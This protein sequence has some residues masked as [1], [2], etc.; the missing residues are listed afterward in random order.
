VN[1]QE[2]ALES[3]TKTGRIFVLDALRGLAAFT[4]IWHHFHFAFA[5]AQS[6]R[7]YLRPF[8]AG[9]EAVMLFFVLSGYV[10]S[11]AVWHGK[12]LPYPRYLIR[13]LTRIYLPYVA[14][15]L[16]SVVVGKHFLFSRLPLHP[17]FYQTWQ[18]PI[19]WRVIAG[20]FMVEPYPKLNTSFWSLQYE[21]QMSL[22]FPLLCRIIAKFRTLGTA[23][24]I[25]GLYWASVCVTRYTSD[26]YFISESLEYCTF[27]LMGALIAKSQTIITAKWNQAGITLKVLITAT[28]FALYYHFFGFLKGRTAFRFGFADSTDV[29]RSDFVVAMGV[30]GII[31]VA[32]SS[33]TMQRLLDQPLFEYL[34]RVSYSMYLL[35]SVVLFS[36]IDMFYGK[37]SLAVLGLGYLVTTMLVSHVF[38]ISVEEPS[39]QWGKRLTSRL[40]AREKAVLA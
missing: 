33:E 16:I 38:L 18:E 7:W 36:F 29:F 24:L 19:T 14:A 12:Q 3:R 26:P 8:T 25:I 34:G 9:H 13:R 27:F 35:H 40:A 23:L 28:S 5:T 21:M 15:M 39:L 17:W 10:L 1:L 20:G 22:I 37:V 4:V 11:V 6:H 32:T 30:I 2:Q 31:V